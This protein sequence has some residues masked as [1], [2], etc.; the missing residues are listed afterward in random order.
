M[1]A[2]SWKQEYK[3]FV[4]YINSN[5]EI[6]LNATEITIP[7]DVR[8]EFYHRFDSIRKSIVDAHYSSLKVDVETLSALYCEVETEV[9]GRLGLEGISMPVDLFSFLHEPKVGMERVIYSRLFDLLQKKTTL[10]DFQEQVKNDLDS[11]SEDLFRLGYEFWAA[12]TTIKIL[13]PDEAYFVD[14]NEDNKPFLTDLNTLAFGR[15]AHHPTIRIPEFVIHSR[16]FNKHLAVK[17]ALARELETYY[18]QY[19][20]PV[21]PKKRTGDTSFALDARAMIL[22]ILTNTEEIPVIAELYDRIIHSPD[23]IIEYVTSDEITNPDVIEQVTRHY[24]ILQ[25]KLGI[26]L[27]VMNPGEGRAVREIS[28]CLSAFGVG[29][30]PSAILPAIN[31]LA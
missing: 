4:D 10:E 5:P 30:D 29:F 31:R 24:N 16:K 23:L 27:F 21:R 28:D 14:L 12:L 13:D 6:V 17:M 25:P 20:P 26:S 7:P 9:I 19:T 3:S 2:S 15:Q 22:S 11:S 18:V 8:E 1:S